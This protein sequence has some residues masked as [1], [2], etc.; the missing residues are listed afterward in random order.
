MMELSL[1][2]SKSSMNTARD[3]SRVGTQTAALGFGGTTILQELQKNMMEL[4][5]HHR[6]G[7]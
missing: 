4:V 7:V 6:T 1:D 2:F 5:G 3:F